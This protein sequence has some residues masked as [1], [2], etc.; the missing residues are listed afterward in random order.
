MSDLRLAAPPST[1]R[2]DV[3]VD[4]TTHTYWLGPQRLAGVTEILTGLGLLTVPSDAPTV[5]LEA[6]RQ[7]GS[8]VHLTLRFLHEGTLAPRSVDPRLDGYLFAWDA[9]CS[10]HMADFRPRSVEQP[11]A[12]P[13]LGFAGTP[14]VDGIHGTERS[15]WV[16]EVKTGPF[17]PGHLLQVAGYTLLVRAGLT[18]GWPT[19]I[20]VVLGADGRFALHRAT[21]R[22]QTIFRA[23]L[24]VWQHRLATTEA[25]HGR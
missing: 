6:A 22:D 24:M 5:R 21:S 8:A 19:G 23:A 17:Q 1:H 12:D 15:P 20:V 16:V 25:P 4:P 14:D 11:Q 18:H 9:F 10:Q 3:R 2:A 13:L 7:R